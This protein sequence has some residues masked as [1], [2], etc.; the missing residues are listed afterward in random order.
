MLGAH[1][2]LVVSCLFPGQGAPREV[3][4]IQGP[5]GGQTTPKLLKTLRKPMKIHSQGPYGTESFLTAHFGSFD[6]SEDANWQNLTSFQS[7]TGAK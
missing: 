3:Q 4:G 5:G 2:Q 6:K 1:G 7:T